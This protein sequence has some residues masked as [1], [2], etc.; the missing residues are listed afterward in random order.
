VLGLT[1]HLIDRS[2]PRTLATAQPTTAVMRSLNVIAIPAASSKPFIMPGYGEIATAFPRRLGLA[3]ESFPLTRSGLARASME[4]D[5]A[6]SG[7][8][9]R[10]PN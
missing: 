1:H 2:Y 9:E 7:A 6:R 10:T 8:M 5:V 4:D 3:R